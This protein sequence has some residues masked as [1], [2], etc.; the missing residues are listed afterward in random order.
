[1]LRTFVEIAEQMKTQGGYKH[2]DLVGW[3]YR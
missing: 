2:R 3:R 1:M